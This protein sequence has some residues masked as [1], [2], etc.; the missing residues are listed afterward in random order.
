MPTYDF[1]CTACKHVFEEIVPLADRE[2]F[3]K[4]SICPKCGKQKLKRLIGSPLFIYDR[5]KTIY[6]RAGD[7]WK[8]VQ[9]KI[10]KGCGR[11]HTIR[12]K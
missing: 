7:G 5:G 4:V 1:Q 10:K 2:E 11:G 9:D 6:K 8:E 12:T 3:T